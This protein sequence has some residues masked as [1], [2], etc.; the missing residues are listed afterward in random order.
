LARM[1]DAPPSVLAKGR[2]RRAAGT[3]LAFSGGDDSCAVVRGGFRRRSAKVLDAFLVRRRETVVVV[4]RRA[5]T[6][7][8]PRRLEE[9]NSPSKR[10]LVSDRPLESRGPLRRRARRLQGARGPPEEHRKP[11]GHH[12]FLTT[13]IA[14]PENPCSGTD[15]QGQILREGP[16]TTIDMDRAECVATGLAVG[17]VGWAHASS[18]DVV[19]S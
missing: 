1:P 11:E 3:T 6:S 13:S 17:A 5:Q 8:R 9:A 16:S 7:R 4:V 18:T 12:L 2:R 15:S 10:R 14:I 19:S